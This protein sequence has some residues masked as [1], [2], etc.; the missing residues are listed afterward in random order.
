MKETEFNKKVQELVE[1]HGGYI[2]KTIVSNKAGVHDMLA[3]I[4]GR[5]CS[6]EG[7]LAYNRMSKLQVAHRNKVILAGGLSAPVKT[8]EDVLQVI[9]WAKT[10]HTQ[11]LEDQQARLRKFTL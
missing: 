5:F 1:A 9:E 10:G 4:N 6:L 8:L 7:K 2:V 11:K 3:C